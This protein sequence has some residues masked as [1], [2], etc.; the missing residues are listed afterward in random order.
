MTVTHYT[1]TFDNDSLLRL[2]LQKKAEIKHHKR[3]VVKIKD[4][5]KSW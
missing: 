5:L 3:S 1:S 2:I 4:V